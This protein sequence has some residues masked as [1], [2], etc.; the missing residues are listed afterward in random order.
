MPIDLA[1]TASHASGPADVAFFSVHGMVALATLTGLEIVLG[2]D[3]IVFIAIQAGRLPER[4]RAKARTVGL[5]LAMVLR[6]GL[7]SVAF[8]VMKLQSG[9]FAV[10]FLEETVTDPETGER[11]RRA[12]ELSGKD[13]VLL[14]GGVFLIWK[15]VKEIHHLVDEGGVPDEGGDKDKPA[16]FVGVVTSILLLDFVFSI[17]SVITAVGMTGSF[18][19]MAAAVVLSVG[20]MLVAAGPIG[21]FVHKHPS[22]KTLA[23][24]FLVLIGVLLFADGLHQ[25]MPRGYVYFSM[26]FAFVVELINLRV[27]GRKRQRAQPAS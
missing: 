27:R 7:L 24:A 10:P 26:A 12:V 9:L 20:V 8:L 25:H 4:K 1:L 2:I 19:I 14:A 15:A 17:D 23:L 22:M 6:L 18:W 21:G 11:V 5:L 16:T 13:L 3:N